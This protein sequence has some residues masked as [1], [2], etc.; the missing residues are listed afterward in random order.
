MKKTHLYLLY[1]SISLVLSYL[2]FFSGNWILFLFPAIAL[3]G[4]VMVIIADI[5]YWLLGNNLRYFFRPNI[6]L[7]A[8]GMYVGSLL[9]EKHH[10]LQASMNE[11]KAKELVSKIDV[12]IAGNHRLPL[13]LR[14]LKIKLPKVYSGFSGYEI[15]Y[16]I[17][18]SKIEYKVSY[19]D[20]ST[21]LEHWYDS[22]L[23]QWSESNMEWAFS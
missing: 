22:G 1:C 17:K 2:I 3:A 18:E 4:C 9:A 19:Y 15:S 20:Y 13:N 23:R 5:V 10:D 11:R 7:A 8:I 16:S 6:V 21:Y 14:E 12:F